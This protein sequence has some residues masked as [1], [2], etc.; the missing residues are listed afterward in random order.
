MNKKSITYTFPDGRVYVGDIKD[1][2]PNGIG[3]MKFSNHDVYEGNWEKGKMHGRGKYYFYD[4]QKEKFSSSYEG[5]FVNNRFEGT[6]VR[7]YSDRT[8]YIGQW[9]NGMRTGNGGFWF[10]DGSYF[11]GIWRFDKMVRGM[12]RLQNGDIYDGEFKDGVFEG[13]GKYHW[14]SDGSF[15]EGLFKEGKC[16]SGTKVFPDGKINIVKDGN[17]TGFLPSKVIE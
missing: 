10:V 12:L 4:S 15:F 17:S 9:Q 11:W 2:V 1:N 14:K 13:Y 8:I 6:G 5:T 16:F 7:K 3:N